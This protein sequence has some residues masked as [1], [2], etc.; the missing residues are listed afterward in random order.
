MDRVLGECVF[1]RHFSIILFSIRIE[2]KHMDRALGECEF[3][4]RFSINIF[5]IKTE[6]KHMD[7]AL[8]E[9]VFSRRFSINPQVIIL[10]TDDIQS[11]KKERYLD[12]N[13]E[14]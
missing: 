4:Q 1:S 10:A 3:S 9:C 13:N 12:N 11:T 8:G 5:W 7:R 2:L 6:L 14:V